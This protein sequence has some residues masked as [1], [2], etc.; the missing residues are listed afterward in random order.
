M[1][2]GQAVQDVL[3]AYGATA[4]S[5]GFGIV[6]GVFLTQYVLGTGELLKRGTVVY[7]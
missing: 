5:V 4:S 2:V 6:V 1:T 7:A 3:D